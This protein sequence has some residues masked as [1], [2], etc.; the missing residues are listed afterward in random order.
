MKLIPESEKTNP[1]YPDL[2]R[3]RLNAR[4]R[5]RKIV[6]AAA[7]LA[8][9]GT[10]GYAGYE[11]TQQIGRGSGIAIGRPVL[12]GV[13]APPIPPPLPAPSSP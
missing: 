1:E 3:H 13:M 6:I 7:T 11:L 10:A 5:R 8:V 2:R 12:M 4:C 9:L